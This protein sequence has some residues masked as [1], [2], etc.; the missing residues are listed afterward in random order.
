MKN[1]FKALLL[2]V[3]AGCF[4]S[5][6]KDENQVVFEGG[7]APVL[8]AST[9]VIPLSFINKDL[10]AFT[11]NWTNPN[12]Q[13]NT[14]LSSQDV[15]YLIEIDTVGANFTNPKRQSISLAKE[16]S[17]TFL[18]T[19]FNDYL[20]NTLQLKPNQPHNVEIRVTA[21]LVN[22]NAALVSNK[23]SFTVT[24][25]PIPPKVNPP[26]SQTLFMVGAATPGGWANPVPVPSQQFTRVS[27]FI[28]VLT[29]NI[30]ANES[31]LFLP[32]NG[33]W[34]AKYGFIGGNNLNNV[35]GDDFKAEGGDMK[36]PAAG[37][38][39]KVEVDF[40]RGKFTLTKL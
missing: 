19:E 4:F 33:S 29:I 17:R 22:N 15:T 2:F 14:G 20:L 32:V 7:T 37:G 25:Y 6:E 11:L 30:V 13:F 34:S 16:L 40:Q 3:I 5:C 23:L 10:P 36:A 24:P 31:Y 8:S 38:S 28:Y 27:E 12:Y 26:A 1:I 21:S 18:Q 39:Y 9:A 35:N